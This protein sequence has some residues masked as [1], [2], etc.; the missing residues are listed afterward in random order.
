MN[1][2]YN[3]NDILNIRDEYILAQ[4][5]YINNIILEMKQYWS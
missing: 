2:N 3:I 1:E 5:Y 4:V